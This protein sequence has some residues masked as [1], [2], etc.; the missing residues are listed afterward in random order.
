MTAF[1]AEKH[2]SVQELAELWSL[3]PKTV[4]RMFEDEPDVMKVSLP[5]LLSGERKHKPHTQLSIPASVATRV[6]KDRCGARSV[7][8]KKGNRVV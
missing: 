7:V 1:A 4:R 3:S 6:H 2:Y 5:R 8:I